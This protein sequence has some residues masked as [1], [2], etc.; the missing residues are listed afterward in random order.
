M[1]DLYFE[2]ELRNRI[3]KQLESNSKHRIKNL[4]DEIDYWFNDKIN[5]GGYA[6]K[7]D[8]CYW[9]TYQE[10]FASSVSSLLD[11]FDFV[12]LLGDTKLSDDEYIVIYRA[13]KGKNIGHH[14]IRIDSD[15]IV[16]EKDANGTPRLFENWGNLEGSE[17]QEAIFAV[18]K[19]HKMFDYGS[20]DINYNNHGL[21]FENTVHRAYLERK[22][23]F[24]YHNHSFYFKRDSQ[25]GIIVIINDENQIVANVFAEGDQILLEV[26]KDYYQYIENYFGKIKPQIENGILKN[27]AEFKKV[28]KSSNEMQLEFDD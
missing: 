24:N 2:T 11:K 8:N 9:P 3:K 4:E 28:A 12:R 18:K 10:N 14:F 27:I 17:I 26:I 15:G 7:I 19:E 6:L 13:P 1:N 21:D 25:T 22:N 23:S 16:R 20:Y 5:C